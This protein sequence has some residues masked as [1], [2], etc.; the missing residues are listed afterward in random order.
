MAEQRDN[1]IQEDH[2][3]LFIRDLRNTELPILS[4]EEIS[5]RI[6][7]IRNPSSSFDDKTRAYS[8]I[9]ASTMRMIPYFIGQYAPKNIPPSD[10]I[11]EAFIIIRSCIDNFDPNQISEKTGEPAKFSTYVGDSLAEVLQSPKMTEDLSTPFHRK[12][13]VKLYL[14]L[15]N[16]FSETLKQKL[17]KEPTVEELYQAITEHLKKSYSDPPL[18]NFDTF[19]TIIKRYKGTQYLSLGSRITSS[20]S[21]TD[22]LIPKERNVDEI[23]SDKQSDPA[24]IYDEVELDTTIKDTLN[25]LTPREKK[26]LEMRYGLGEYTKEMN[27][28]QIAKELGLNQEVVR[29]TLAHALRKLRHPSRAKGLRPFYDDPN[30]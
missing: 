8:E 13:T 18:L 29:I 22:T 1:N 23:T 14:P 15:I 28:K 5:K 25:T 20:Q 10:L 26:V 2:Y 19:A 21:F 4:D 16:R 12:S 7:T 6:A 27:E 9:Y 11:S 17:Q 30:S 3:T 24:Q